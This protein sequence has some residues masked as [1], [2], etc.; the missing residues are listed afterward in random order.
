MVNKKIEN[1]EDKNKQAKSFNILLI[2]VLILLAIVTVFEYVK[3]KK[4]NLVSISMIFILFT[5]TIKFNTLT[6][7]ILK[8]S[9][10][11]IGVGIFVLDVILSL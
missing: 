1:S 4:L 2:V 9:C 3:T 8:I 10:L 5:S 11:V 6:Q 7:K